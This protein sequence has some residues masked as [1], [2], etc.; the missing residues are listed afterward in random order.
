M[1]LHSLA[2][3][4]E[5]VRNAEAAAVMASELATTLLSDD[6][7]KQDSPPGAEVTVDDLDRRREQLM[8]KEVLDSVELVQKLLIGVTEQAK[9]VSGAEKCT[10]WLVRPK[11]GIMWS[12]LSDIEGDR[13]KMNS[14][15][16]DTSDIK[17]RILRIPVGKGLAGMCAEAGCDLIIADGRHAATRASLILMC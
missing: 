11:T 13:V 6:I 7:E 10:L 12:F 2:D 8:A 5:R 4:L 9:V 3:R 14:S 15:D 17:R 16:E 1:C